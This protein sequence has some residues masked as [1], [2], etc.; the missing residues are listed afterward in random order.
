MRTKLL[1]YMLGG[2]AA[3][4]AGLMQ[5]SRL[6]VGDPTVAVGLELEIIAAVVIGGASLSGGVGS[7]LG[8]LVGAAIM[9]TIRVGSSH[10]GWPNYRQEKITGI[11]IILA[12]AL[13]T[14][15]QRKTSRTE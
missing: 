15:R 6:S 8:S 7:P 9:T 10:M 1:V 2:A 14:L 12:V 3:G 13:D 4:I 5:F 11:I